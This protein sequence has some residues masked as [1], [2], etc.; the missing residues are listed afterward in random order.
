MNTVA[1]K[2][3]TLAIAVLIAGYAYASNASTAANKNASDIV[4]EAKKYTVRV[5]CTN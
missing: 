4:A 3:L 1:V 5:Q 2:W